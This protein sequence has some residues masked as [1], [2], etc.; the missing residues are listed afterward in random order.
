MDV[1]TTL[2]NPGGDLTAVVDLDVARKSAMEWFEKEGYDLKGMLEWPVAWGDCDMFQHV[3]NVQFVKWIESARIRY[4]ESLPLPAKL[5]RNML[6][7]KG[8]G[9]ILK[10][11]TVQYRRPVTWPDSVLIATRV[12]E[13]TQPRASFKLSNAIWSLKGNY[14]AATA[15]STM[16]MY[17][18][19]NIKKGA[20]SDEFRIALESR[21]PKPFVE[22][23]A[24]TA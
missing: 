23:Q 16:V 12:Y 13:I 5:I 4:C 3:N 11:V 15:D 8:T 1:I 17:D 24:S 7:G 2:S 21:I 22:E 9:F 6:S 19:D 20:M 10:D 14:L 18:Y